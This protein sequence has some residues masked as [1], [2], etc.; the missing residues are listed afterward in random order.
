MVDAV[1][2]YATRLGQRGATDSLQI[3]SISPDGIVGE[4]TILIGP[5]SELMAEPAGYDDADIVDGPAIADLRAR[6]AAL[7]DV[8]AAPLTEPGPGSGAQ[9]GIPFDE[10]DE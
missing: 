8:K 3:P 9:G 6:T 5:S 4:S 10:F 2:D 7:G 1:V